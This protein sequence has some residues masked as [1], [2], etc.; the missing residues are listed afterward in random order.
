MKSI[1]AVLPLLVVLF[2]ATRSQTSLDK[3]VSCTTDS[4]TFQLSYV[5]AVYRTGDTLSLTRRIS[6]LSSTEAYAFALPMNSVLPLENCEAV[7]R[8]GG[9]WLINLGYVQAMRLSLIAPG[10]TV[11]TT[12]EYIISADSG[13]CSTPWELVTL[14]NPKA[15]LANVYFDVGL[16]ISSL[17]ETEFTVEDSGALKFKSVENEI[18]FESR[19]RRFVLGP[20]ALRIAV[21]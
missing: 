20:I 4:V 2:G 14:A 13:Q 17:R 9:S 8:W 3:T 6:N 5:D 1:C 16:Y 15:K 18:A 21:E 7:I 11:L 10:R 19:L 12:I